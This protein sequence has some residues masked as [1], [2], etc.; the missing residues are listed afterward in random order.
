MSGPFL[1]VLGT[2]NVKKRAELMRLLQSDPIEVRSLSDF[3]A[4]PEAEETGSTFAENAAIKATFYAQQLQQWVLAEDSGLSVA[5]LGGEPGVYSARFSGENAT[6]ASNN[7]LLLERLQG[8]PQDK[9]NAWYTCHIALADSRGQIRA[10]AEAECHGVI[11][12]KQCGDAGFGYDPLFQIPEYK[13][14][15]GEL[16]DDV[17]SILSHRGRAYRK[18]L[19][20]LLAVARRAR[21]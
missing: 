9:R 18:F 3:A 12:D 17:K 10:C 1:L 11:L 2:N 8:I 16:G 19:P 20:Q 15:F 13:R 14:T 7:E 6:D 4:V 5:A 21:I